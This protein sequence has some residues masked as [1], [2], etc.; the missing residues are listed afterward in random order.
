MKGHP[1][2]LLL[3]L[4]LTLDLSNPFMPGAVQFVDGRLDVVDAGRPPG[5]DVPMPAVV[6]GAA[7]AW[8]GLVRSRLLPRLTA[9]GD[10][11][12]P[13]IPARRAFP[14]TADPAPSPDDH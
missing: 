8:T 12:R 14:S 7:P 5:N 1:L 2:A 3:F 9:V 13:W 11:L 6:V 4:Y 10:R